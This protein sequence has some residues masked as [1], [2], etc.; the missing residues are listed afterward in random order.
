[1]SAETR[2]PGVPMSQWPSTYDYVL[3]TGAPGTVTLTGK[4]V[5]TVLKL[6]DRLEE[7]DDVQNVYANFEIPDDEL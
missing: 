5:D 7:H 1:M 2:P 4:D 3:P 6:V